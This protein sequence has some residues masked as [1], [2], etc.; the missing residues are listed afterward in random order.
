MKTHH[1]RKGTIMLLVALLANFA[2]PA[3]ATQ[4]HGFIDQYNDPPASITIWCGIPPTGNLY[5]SFT[6]GGNP[7]LLS[8]VDLRLRV[9]IRFPDS[10]YATT[11]RIRTGSPTGEILG[12]A[13]TFV[14]GPQTYGSQL[15]VHFNFKPAPVIIKPG[16][17]YFIEWES[18][19]DGINV[20]SWLGRTDNPYP[21]GILYACRGNPKP[22]YDQNFITYHVPA[23]PHAGNE[24][25]H[26]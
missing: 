23:N 21:D 4:A 26:P 6:P 20:L 13:T 11:I 3:L 7:P 12:E 17:I 22:Q 9:G 24:P 19:E 14:P 5:Q 8:G 10:G 15:L 16:T 18:P 2:L 25:G 1:F